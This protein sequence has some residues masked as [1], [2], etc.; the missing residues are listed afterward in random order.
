[1]L[2]VITIATSKS[3]YVNYA[4]NLA[5]SFLYWHPKNNIRFYLFTDLAHVVPNYLKEKINVV[6]IE[7]ES[8]GEGFSSK[9]Y[10]DQLAPVGQTLFI[11]SDCLVFGDL[12]NIF[13]KFKGKQVSVVGNYISDGEWFGDIKKICNAF[14]V[15]HLPKF[16]GGIYY[17]EKGEIANQIYEQA[18][19]IEKKYDEIGFVRLRNKPNDE[20]IMALAMQLN[21]QSPLLDDG[22]I[23]SDMQACQGPYELD[24]INGYTALNNPSYPS[25]LH[26][27]WYPFTH[28]SPL[29]VHFLGQFTSH[30]TYLLQ[31]YRVKK[32]VLGELSFITE[33][34][35]KLT[36]S[37]P[38]QI[39]NIVKN[40]FR[41]IY[42][43]LIGFRKIAPSERI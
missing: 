25:P 18:R 13:E 12:T 41:P 17:L 16:N 28:V 5:N 3:V 20:V 14:N 23:M 11:D 34:A 40:T 37:Y 10:L 24:V 36:I 27:D 39:K 43:K 19:Q 21:Q 2:N 29:V 4:V 38:E 22:S 7:P 42:R 6:Q 35:G 9:L 8:L 1:M 32:A 30:Y 26:Q 31:S 33:L 15:P